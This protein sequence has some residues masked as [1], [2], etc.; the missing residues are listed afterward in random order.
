MK[1]HTNLLFGCFVILATILFL[2]NNVLAEENTDTIIDTTSTKEFS[3]VKT[4]KRMW[5]NTNDQT[6]KW[7]DAVV[8]CE[9]LELGGHDD[10][11]LPSLDELQGIVDM[12]ADAA[13]YIKQGFT[14]NR[15]LHYW[16]A[17]EDDARM[18]SYMDFNTGKPIRTGK[19]NKKSVRCV[20]GPLAA[21]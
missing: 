4:F 10:W 20:R 13:P 16:S 8:F 17:E 7:P 5:Q 3:K 12:K 15:I 1:T 19:V 6:M 2:N 18:A 21:E 11:R 9:N 14:V